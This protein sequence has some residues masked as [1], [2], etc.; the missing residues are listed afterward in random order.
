M[1]PPDRWASPR[2]LLLLSDS[3]W[4]RHVLCS[5]DTLSDSNQTIQINTQRSES[6]YVA[7]CKDLNFNKAEK[8]FSFLKK[9]YLSDGT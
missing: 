8:T 1:H 6:R 2:R 7:D 4:F 5:E 9:N 3:T